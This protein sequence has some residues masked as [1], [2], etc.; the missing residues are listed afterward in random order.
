MTMT[1]ERMIVTPEPA[2]TPVDV[3]IPVTRRRVDHLLIGAGA[4][5]SVV[6][7]VAGALLLWGNDFAEDYVGDELTAQNITFPPEEVLLE[8]GRDDLVGFAGEQVTTGAHAEAYASFIGGHV[9][10]IGGGLSYA[11][12]GGPERAAEAALTEAV[13]A[14]APADEVAEL[15][16]EAAAIAGQ[17]ETIFR[18]EM[19]RGTLLN[20]F[21]WSTM[22]RIAGI[23]ATVAFVGAAFM[24]LLSLAGVLHLRTVTATH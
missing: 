21:A 24:A 17:R 22:G 9:A 20:A 3:P 4:V 16:A 14:G 19:L 6:L 2:A 10:D 15:E 1:E 12:L 7:V 11:E 23:A 5:V 18:G 8:E 13:A